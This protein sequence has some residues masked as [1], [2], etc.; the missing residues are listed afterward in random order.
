MAKIA[1]KIDVIVDEDED[2][3]LVDELGNQD[4]DVDKGRD[5]AIRRIVSRFKSRG[6][7]SERLFDSV[8][9]Y[10]SIRK[11]FASIFCCFAFSG[12]QF[13][14]ESHPEFVRIGWLSAQNPERNNR[15]ESPDRFCS[16]IRPCQFASR[17]SFPRAIVDTWLCPRNTSTYSK[18]AVASTV[19]TDHHHSPFWK[20]VHG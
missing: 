19:A 14:E 3:V 2:V 10:S 13:S 4:Q 18:N 1:S 8:T 16:R 11:C 6:Q 7:D 15:P 9:S 17:N 12:S 5:A 20:T